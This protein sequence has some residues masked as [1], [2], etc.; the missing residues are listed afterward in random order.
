MNVPCNSTELIQFDN[1]NRVD[2]DVKL[3]FESYL[4]LKESNRIHLEV[5]ID[6][7]TVPGEGSI[8]PSD[9]DQKPS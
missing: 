6:G 3:V 4:H 2:L 1:L 5:T 8:N 7:C 9:V